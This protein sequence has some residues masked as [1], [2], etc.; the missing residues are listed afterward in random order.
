MAIPR[1]PLSRRVLTGG[2]SASIESSGLGRPTYGLGVLAAPSH[3]AHTGGMRTF[4]FLLLCLVTTC[5]PCTLRAQPLIYE[6]CENAAQGQ[7]CGSLSFSQDVVGW[8]GLL[9]PNRYSAAWEGRPETCLDY[10]TEQRVTTTEFTVEAFV[11]S[12]Q[13]TEYAAIASDWNEEGDQ[14]SWAFVLTPRGGLRFDI[15]PDGAFHPS[16]KLE[17]AGRLI[18]PGRWYHVAA[19]SS[20][21]LSRIYVNG[22]LVAEGQRERRDLHR[23]H[24]TSEDRKRGPLRH[25]RAAALARTA[26]RSPH[27]FCG[28]RSRQVLAHPRAVAAAD[29]SGSTSV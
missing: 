8:G 23:R 21:K 6:R 22:Y 7:V 1:I 11:K 27:H 28:S 16:N 10:G 20:G 26:G 24:G 9:E 25:L 4:L 12:S 29:R 19:V 3:A 13:R 18:E 17:T 5:W 2:C 14:R 15:S